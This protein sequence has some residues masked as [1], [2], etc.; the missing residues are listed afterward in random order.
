MGNRRCCLAR[1]AEFLVK[2]SLNSSQFRARFVGDV[3]HP[4]GATIPIAGVAQIALDLVQHGVNPRGRGIVFV[5][6]DELMRG[7]P[8]AG[9]S[10]F[11]RL[12][13]FIFWRAHGRC[14]ILLTS[15]EPLLLP[16]RDFLDAFGHGQIL[17]HRAAEFV[18]CL[19]DFAAYFV[20]NPVG[21][22]FVPHVFAAQLFLGLRG[23]EK[24]GRQFR[25]AHVIKNMLLRLEPLALMEAHS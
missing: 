12:E 21:V 10:Q 14:L 16:A 4:V 24:I 6:L 17:R 3:F 9:Q 18:N 11:H 23:A 13:Q 20:V 7:V 2:F 25:A 5:L 8:L 19:A 1:P 22:I 15:L